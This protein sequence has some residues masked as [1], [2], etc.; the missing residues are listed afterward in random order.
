MWGD[1]GKE[2]VPP[3]SNFVPYPY[4]LDVQ[5]GNDN[6][7]VLYSMSNKQTSQQD[8]RYDTLRSILINEEGEFVWNSKYVDLCTNSSF[9]MFISLSEFNEEQWVAIWGD[10]RNTLIDYKQ[11]IYGQNVNYD[12]TIGIKNT[13]VN[14]NNSSDLFLT[15]NPASDYLEINLE[16]C[17]TL[18][19][20]RTSEIKI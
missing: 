11:E 20:C 8:N 12:G 15:P 1:N 2:F 7:L 13:S 17:Q 16:R 3:V 9:K 10:S 18:S 19:K 4:L 14:Q 6:A 5:L